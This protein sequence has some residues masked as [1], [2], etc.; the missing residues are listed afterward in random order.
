MDL[1]Y[2]RLALLLSC[3]VLSFG[4][5]FTATVR[6][7]VTDA[8][9]AAVS[10]AAVVAHELARGIQH[11]T[12]ADAEGRYILSALPVGKYT[13]TV[14]AAGFKKFLQQEFELLVQQ[15]AN[16][17]VTLTV[18]EVFS[19]IEISTSAPLLNTTS[20]S[21]GQVVENRYIQALPL[22]GRSP[23]SLTQLA[24]GIT[25]VNTSQ[26]SVGSSTNFVASGTRNSTADVLLDGMS[27]TNIEQN[28]GVTQ[29]KYQPSV[30]VV[31]EFK[32][33]TN[34]LAAEYGNTGAAIINVVTKSGTNEFHGV[35]YEFHRNAALNAN[36]W[37]ANRNGRALPD[38]SR[39]VFGGTLGG[40]VWIPKLYQGRNKT[41]FFVDYEG[42]R[43]SSATTRTAT[44]PTEM[45][46]M[47]DFSNTRTASGALFVIYNPYDTYKNAAGVTLRN[48]FPG[49]I[50]PKNLQNPIALK[51]LSYY[52]NP[53]SAGNALSQIN[54]FFVQG[55]NQNTANQMDFKIDHLISENNRISSRYSRNRSA[56]LPANLWGNPADRFTDGD[57]RTHT[58]N[59]VFD[60][61]RVQSAN[62]I[63]NARVGVTRVDNSRIPQSFGFDPTTLGL[64][65]LYNTSAV[66]LFPSFSPD[67]YQAMGTNGYA[68]IGRGE[69]VTSLT[70]SFTWNTGGHTFKGGWEGR[71]MRMNYLQPGY[72]QGNFNFSRATT[73]ENPLS[74]A[75]ATQ[76]NG[77]ASM[78]L[79]WG[80]G[81]DYHLDPWSASASKYFGFYLQDDWKITR[82]LTLNLGLR[83]DF[84]LPR[85]ERYDRLS[86]FDFDAPSPLAGKVPAFPNLKGQFKFTDSNTRSPIDTDMNNVQ[87][88]IGFA[89]ALTPKTA[90]RGGYGILYTT[91]RATIKG[92]TGSGYT[93]N[94]SVQFSRDGGITQYATL[95]N[96]Y[97]NG[98]TLPPGNSQGD[99][100]FLG[101]GIGT[102]GRYNQ[103]P[104]IQAWNFS[105]QRDVG[106]NSVLEV[107]YTGTKGTHL[108]F[109]GLE[110]R[111][112]LDPQ[113]WSLGR[114]ALNAQVPN[115]FYGIITNPQST[116]SQPT[117]QRSVLLRPFPQYNGGVSGN[118]P[119]N[120]NSIYHALQV[121]YEKRF[122][123]GLSALLHYTWSKSIDDTALTNG[124]V[125]WLGSNSSVQ[126]RYDL[127]QE[128][129]LSIND[130]PHRFLATF[131]YQLPVGRGRSFGSKMNG[132]ADA[133][134]GGWEVSGIATISA[135]F[136]VVPALT[137]GQ[138]WDAT[139]RP[140]LIGDPSTSGRVQ[141]RLN[142]YI[143]PAAFSKPAPDTYGSAPRTLS[144]HT[145]G[146][147]VM[148]LG[149]L[150][151]FR[152]T[153]QRYFQFRA[154]AFN[155]TNTPTFSGPGSS[156][157]AGDFGVISGTAV[158][159]R[160]VQLALKFYY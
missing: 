96:P 129:S 65:S 80:S 154:E 13:L 76:G 50:I 77:I 31:Q 83:Y 150:K 141:D 109:G 115:P 28:S 94:S 45:E 42:T 73:A 85:T 135:G 22:A 119:N 7:S 97:P 25:P 19:S 145:P 59:G 156:F 140:N 120:S 133:V 157:G 126:N 130:V 146:V 69:D 138:L 107:N 66:G 75:T 78:L 35:G 62:L 100:T 110:N 108:Y 136:P 58:Q 127:R 139:Q 14:E 10:G 18:G 30:D 92:H 6:G 55:V 143:N 33:A 20:S 47:G 82:N 53:T 54:N 105:V 118:T 149:L 153:E 91:S 3:A 112:V 71:F 70:S 114:T 134:V 43:Q 137:G 103:N 89:Y 102:D 46:R 4:Q 90:V 1:R 24:P 116:L 39:N 67:S 144:Y 160:Q 34:A 72:P 158:G 48:P 2:V 86:W 56:G 17:D 87:P 21:L 117:V 15:Q 41:F 29:L 27:V 26:G 132:F 37:F 128:R 51:A 101:L 98:L 95:Q 99:A 122:T 8:Q 124:N 11:H 93:T 123:K 61:T 155:F 151:N 12:T 64:S 148:D 49:N 159:A 5:S 84:D 57:D 111:N 106:F 44:L 125:A 152:F 16:I 23:L 142:N 131:N 121:R 81:G 60:F 40:P 113:Y 74:P 38:F 9:R 32:V 68:L 147:R 104:Q 52:P 63:L 36:D 79:G 88:R